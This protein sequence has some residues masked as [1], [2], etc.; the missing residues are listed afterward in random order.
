MLRKQDEMEKQQSDQAA[1]NGFIFYTVALLLWA[2]VNQINSHGD[3]GWAFI[4]LMGGVMVYAFTRV[5][6]NRKVR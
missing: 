1:K 2:I 6:Y 3:G 5:Y 4:I